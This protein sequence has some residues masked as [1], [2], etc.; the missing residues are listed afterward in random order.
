MAA[1]RKRVDMSQTQYAA[2]LGTSQGRVSRIETGHERPTKGQAL[3][4]SEH[5]GI[6]AH[7]WDKVELAN[8]K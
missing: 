8:S 7:H 4:L 2:W 5:A 1:H 6:A 3:Q